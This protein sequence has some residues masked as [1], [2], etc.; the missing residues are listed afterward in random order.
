VHAIGEDVIISIFYDIDINEGPN[1]QDSGVESCLQ[2]VAFLYR[3]R[4]KK[5]GNFGRSGFFYFHRCNVNELYKPPR[6]TDL[7]G[8]ENRANLRS[9]GILRSWL[10]AYPCF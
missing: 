2:N 8:H 10:I 5:K 9:K 3:I 7:K 4:I 6:R 1:F